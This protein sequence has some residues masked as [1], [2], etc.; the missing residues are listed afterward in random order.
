MTKMGGKASIN[1]Q[2]KTAIVSKPNVP[3][4]GP[5]VDASKGAPIVRTTGRAKQVAYENELRK[6]NMTKMGGKGSI[7]QP[8]TTIVSKPIVAKVGPSVVA[9]KGAPMTKVGGNAGI[10][11]LKTA[12]ATK[13]NKN[14][15]NMNMNIPKLGATT[16]V[17]VPVAASSAQPMMCF[18]PSQA[19]LASMGSKSGVSM[20]S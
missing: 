8:K 15:P 6:K 19:D 2:P 1:Q 17:G 13:M 20:K 5:S 3:K 10:N 7:N 12:L 4:V 18:K 9:S 11:Q 14:I 16:P